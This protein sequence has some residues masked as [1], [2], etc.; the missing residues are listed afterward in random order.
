MILV[1]QVFP[2][3]NLPSIEYDHA[4]IAQHAAAA[5]AAAGH[6]RTAILLQHTGSAADAS[7]CDAFAAARK[8]GTPAPL[9]LEHD[10]SL[11]QIESR[12]RRLA[13]LEPRPTSL[14]VTK[15]LAAPAVLT[16]LPR[17][18]VEIPRNLSV[19]CREDDPFLEY[20]V[21]AVARYSSDSS[22]I[23]RKLAVA[24]ARLAQGLPLKV[25]HARLMPRFVGG[26][27]VASVPGGSRS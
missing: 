8:P 15:S 16:I 7:T 18:G 2:G 27:S 5:L 3:I 19:I 17:L 11:A 26:R 12:L 9:V 20:L 6:E 4:A 23:A 13:R 14:F 1:G 25:T 22:A 21:P 10:G 24:L